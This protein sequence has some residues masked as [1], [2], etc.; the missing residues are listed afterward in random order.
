[1]DRCNESAILDKIKL[2]QEFDS[3]VERQKTAYT[4]HT[5]RYSHQNLYGWV[6][7]IGIPRCLSLLAVSYRYY[8]PANFR[9]GKLL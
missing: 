3:M 2:S 7:N 8:K 5:S 9:D 4:R 1:M 6:K